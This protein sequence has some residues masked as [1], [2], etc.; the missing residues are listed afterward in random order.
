MQKSY[1]SSGVVI[2][3]WKGFYDD[4]SYI[5][6]WECVFFFENG[7]SVMVFYFVFG[8]LFNIIMN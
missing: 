2:V 3:Y 5:K 7:E 4:E 1:V 6:Y 8:S